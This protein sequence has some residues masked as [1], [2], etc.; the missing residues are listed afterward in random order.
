MDFLHPAASSN[1]QL[2]QVTYEQLK[3]TKKVAV[4]F[5]SDTRCNINVYF[6][7]MQHSF[8]KARQLFEYKLIEDKMEGNEHYY[9]LYRNLHSSN[10]LK[11]VFLNPSM[12][13]QNVKLMIKQCP[14]EK[15]QFTNDS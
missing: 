14:D 11:I 6:Q 10:G 2:M 7:E 9:F 15:C 5:K 3:Q 4:Q 13:Y 12:E 8:I 1:L